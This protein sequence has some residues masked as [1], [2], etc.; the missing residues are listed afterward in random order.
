MSEEGVEKTNNDVE[1]ALDTV[2]EFMEET[3]IA[4]DVSDELEVDLR[5]DRDR[6][7]VVGTLD[8]EADD[9]GLIIGKRGQ[10]LDAIQYLANAVVMANMESAIPVEVD[11]QG[12]KE[13]RSS[14]LIKIA[15]RAAAKAARTGNPV[16][17][18]PMT[19]TERKVI[20]LH[21]KDNPDVETESSGFGADRHLVVYPA[22]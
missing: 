22:K 6:D 16:D 10:T 18:D 15:D 20:H 4:L 8:G 11:A 17:L 2:A 1:Q 7:K 3:L 5:Y 14:Q 12:Y 19:N 13:R 9:I 21:L